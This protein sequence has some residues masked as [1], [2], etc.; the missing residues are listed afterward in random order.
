[1]V[2]KL[3]ICSE[4]HVTKEK[5]Y[6]GLSTEAARISAK[7]HGE[8]ILCSKKSKSFF[9]RF[10]SAFNDPIIKIL[11]GA[12][13]INIIFHIKDLDLIETFGIG[14][15]VLISTL[16]SA[17]SEY[18]SEKAYSS[19][20]K[21]TDTSQVTVYRDGIPV[22]LSP[23][24]LVVGDAVIL[25]PG[26]KIRADGYISHGC[27]SVDQ[28]AL[29]G[30]S[31]EVEKR[32]SSEPKASDLSD[33]CS[34]FSGTLI[35]GGEG[36]MTVTAVGER[37][38]YGGIASEL[39]FDTGDSP[40]KQKLR[41]LASTISRYGYISAILVAL[42]DLFNSLI[43]DKGFDRIMI[44]QT[45]SDPASLFS[46][47]LHAL[48]LA[49]T[50][51]IVAVPEGLPMMIGVVLSR[52][53][54]KM[55]ADNVMVRTPVGIETAGGINILFT[56]KTG[57]LTEGKMSVRGLICS[58]GE[59]SVSEIPEHISTHYAV[60]CLLDTSCIQTS[61]GITGGNATDRALFSSAARHKKHMGAFEVL[62]RSPFSSDSKYSSVTVMRSGKRMTYIKGAPD[63][64]L[65][66]C[67][68][69]LSRSGK[70]IPFDKKEV[71]VALKNSAASAYRTVAVAYEH[72]SIRVFVCAAKLADGVRRTSKNA[73]SLLSDAGVDTVMI[74]G[75][76]EETAVSIAKQTGIL[77]KKRTLSVTGQRLSQL[78]DD[79][80]ISIL[81]RLAVVARAY[82]S[83]KS[84]LVRLC[85]QSGLVV[86]MTGDGINDSPALRC[87]DVGFAMG[88]GCD[89]AKEAGDIVIL[90]DDI[91]SIAK[92]VLYGRTIFKSIKK[93]LLFQL[94]MN[95]CAVAVS[96]LAPLI[97]CETP[98]T[99]V[100]M[101]WI[102]IIM[103]TLAALAFAGEEPREKY[104]TEKPIRRDEKVLTSSMKKQIAFTGIFSTSLMVW[105]LKSQ[106]VKE[107]FGFYHSPTAFYC[108]FFGLFVF[109]GIFNCFNARTHRINLFSHLSHNRSFC[110]IIASVITVQLFLMYFGGEV[111]RCT[112]LTFP[113]LM[114]V[115]LSA[116]LVIPADILRKIFQR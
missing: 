12:L 80:V 21:E 84:R 17:S 68:C 44:V 6:M 45:L 1:M 27:V 54:S 91:A 30:E 101:L 115:I 85:K 99:V 39:T 34:L 98:V 108:G 61:D 111:F 65:P 67:G 15:A 18:G 49:L 73:V 82:P 74:T 66:L 89:V 75:D 31:E 13:L 69:C 58:D 55:K 25:R 20:L 64:I 70:E 33:S 24:Y 81:P 63:I 102:N 47:I 41:S 92:T 32:A 103:D 110:F 106:T 42:A 95:F 97:G 77:N 88:S 46:N 23:F 87:A 11:L 105:F 40:L 62:S 79:E 19:L 8:N 57:T 28:S 37:T 5:I 93:F 43:L 59:V 71:I 48:T 51:V 86:G 116:I 22:S 36:I 29:N 72:D 114:F 104:M 26:E 38:F 96:L 109:L 53:I 4:V 3:C 52:N 16:I 2:K 90:D 60:S 100:Q 9:S 10:L 113:E 83:D 14:A 94:T 56:D 76:S 78:S 35:C 112:P 107:F 7:E 50:V